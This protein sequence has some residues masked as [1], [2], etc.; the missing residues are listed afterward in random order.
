MLGGRSPSWRLKAQPLKVEWVLTPGLVDF[1]IR[2]VILTWGPSPCS[3]GVGKSP[4]LICS[5][6]L[7]V[8]QDKRN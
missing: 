5:Y 4:I 6:C 2:Q 3:Q 7:L 8:K 1:A